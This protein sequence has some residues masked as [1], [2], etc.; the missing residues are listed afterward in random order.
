MP[1]EVPADTGAS[2]ARR[3]SEQLASTC[4]VGGAIA[5]GEEAVLADAA[6]ALG[7]HVHEQ[8]ADEL[9]RVE[10]PGLPP[11]WPFD[12]VVL[13][14]ERDAGIA[15][16]SRSCAGAGHGLAGFAKGGARLM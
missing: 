12:A 16:E 2:H 1:A 8:A 6:E 9:V 15:A 10:R 5:I 4:D 7:Q 3:G 11:G 13:P 14:T